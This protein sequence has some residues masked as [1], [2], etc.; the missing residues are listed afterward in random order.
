MYIFTEEG[1]FSIAQDRDDHELLEI[2]ARRL[3]DLIA[4]FP[5]REILVTPQR[6]YK[7]RVVVPKVEA[8]KVFANEIVSIDYAMFERSIEDTAYKVLCEQVCDLAKQELKDE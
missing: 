7:Y 8:A 1:F 5:G 2:R 3:E 6:D 4:Q